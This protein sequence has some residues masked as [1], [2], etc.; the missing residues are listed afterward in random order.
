MKEQQ[1]SVMLPAGCASLLE[2]RE[3]GEPGG[4]GQCPGCLS[5]PGCVF[6]IFHCSWDVG[7]SHAYSSLS[8]VEPSSAGRQAGLRQG[9]CSWSA[10][11]VLLSQT[12]VR[13]FNDAKNWFA[14]ETTSGFHSQPL[15]VCGSAEE[16]TNPRQMPLGSHL[17]LEGRP[18]MALL[19]ARQP[20]GRLLQTG[21]WRWAL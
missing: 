14:M 3:E 10:A 7:L 20:T 17:L 11:L 9:V 8:P 21:S 19:L 1:V 2:L 16:D 6:F 5:A 13:I 4:A 15:V 12:Q 18:G